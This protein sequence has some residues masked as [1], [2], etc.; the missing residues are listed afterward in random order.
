MVILKR[1]AWVIFA[2]SAIGRAAILHPSD[3]IS[4]A[5]KSLAHCQF[6]TARY[7]DAQLR[8]LDPGLAALYRLAW[9]QQAQSPAQIGR[10]EVAGEQ[11]GWKFSSEL[12]SDEQDALNDSL[13]CS[14]KNPP[15]GFADLNPSIVEDILRP[16]LE[17]VA[18]LPIEAQ[19]L[20]REWLFYRWQ[21]G[22]KVE[23]DFGSVPAT[24]EWNA[25]GALYRGKTEREPR[26]LP[27]VR[28][29]LLSA[30]TVLA[31]DE[32][33][34][35]GD[36]PRSASAYTNALHSIAGTPPASLWYRVAI[37]SLR[38]SAHSLAPLRAAVSALDPNQAD[39]LEAPFR[40]QLGNGVC[41]W[42][43]QFDA[44]EVR[45]GFEKISGR[46]RWRRSA[47]SLLRQCATP[48]AQSLA[49]AL[50]KDSTNVRERAELLARLMGIAERS[51][52]ISSAR[53]YASRLAKLSRVDGS[54]ANHYFW[55]EVTSPSSGLVDV[56]RRQASWGSADEARRRRVRDRSNDS[57]DSVRAHRVLALPALE[58]FPKISWGSPPPID[59]VGMFELAADRSPR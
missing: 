10:T 29:D 15:V 28:S 36:Y 3:L 47:L 19:K 21:I 40:T 55:K 4:G 2:L 44:S 38:G 49:R 59:F 51:S 39:P 27:Q 45:R 16:L 57:V 54:L 14:G 31:G 26:I 58:T 32:A 46:A 11:L 50:L 13:R 9:L 24:P 5:S 33:Y 25:L 42:L 22:T 20:L 12:W 37:A 53:G 23:W 48:G 41:D 6:H 1:G 34:I 18:S 17:D 8:D 56:F 52:E 30:W 35:Q 43:G 7:W